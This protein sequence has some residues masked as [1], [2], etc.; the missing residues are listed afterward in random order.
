MRARCN[1]LYKPMDAP[2]SHVPDIYQNRWA[3]YSQGRP[4]SQ[5]SVSATT[6]ETP[7]IP[8]IAADAHKPNKSLLEVFEDELAKLSS[9]AQKPKSSEGLDTATSLVPEKDKKPRRIS[10]ACCMSYSK[11]CPDGQDSF[12]MSRGEN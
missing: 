12:P 6:N 8:P 3:S 4:P 10:E 2:G 1:P 11:H 5:N 7:C 9:D